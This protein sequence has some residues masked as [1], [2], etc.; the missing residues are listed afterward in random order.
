MTLKLTDDFEEEFV[1]YGLQSNGM[2]ETKFVFNLNRT[3]QARFKRLNDLDIQIKGGIF[4]FSL[5]HFE[6]VMHDCEYFLMR[7]V[8]HPKLSFSQNSTLFDEIE[9]SEM[10]LNKFRN[11]DY[12]LKIPGCFED[13]PLNELTLRDADYIQNVQVI[14]N[15]NQKERNLLTI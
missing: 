10:I 7:N 13:V 2:D 5:Y 12:F 8:S 1:L 15:L 11:F 14:E 6:D 9:E 4:C 3:F